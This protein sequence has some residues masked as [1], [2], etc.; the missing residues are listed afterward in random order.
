MKNKLLISGLTLLITLNIFSQENANQLTMEKTT[1]QKPILGLRTVSYKVGDIAKAKEWYAKAF[2]T[3]PY[4][5]EPFYVGFN[6]GGYELGLQPDE[7]PPTEKTESVVAF[8]GVNDI[9]KEYNRFLES[10]AVEHEK[11]TNVGGEIVIA[12]VKDPWGNII[13]LIYNPEFRIAK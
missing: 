11:P 1:N 3:E 9:E 10:E 4:F 12:S 6:I 8:W 7:N 13:G 5:D 2:Q